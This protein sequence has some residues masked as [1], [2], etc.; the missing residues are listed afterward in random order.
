MFGSDTAAS[1]F[2][3]SEK[4]NWKTRESNTAV[5][6]IQVFRSNLTKEK[7]VTLQ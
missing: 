4:K 2:I 7:D 6:Y 3:L 1:Q 5:K